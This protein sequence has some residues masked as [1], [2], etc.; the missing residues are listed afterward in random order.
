MEE[1]PLHAFEL[2]ELIPLV[3]AGIDISINKAVILM[4][5]VVGLVAFIMISAAAARK[6]VPGKLQNM[7]ELIVEFI[8]GIILDTMGEPA[9]LRVIHSLVAIPISPCLV[10][11]RNI[12]SKLPIKSEPTMDRPSRPSDRHWPIRPSQ[13]RT[14]CR[15]FMEA[16]SDISATIWFARSNRCPHGPSTTSAP[17]TCTWS[18]WTWWPPSIIKPASYTSCFARP[19][20]DSRLSHAKNSIAKAATG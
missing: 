6:L 17:R 18:F 1:S 11:R 20:P 19:C 15:P 2:H 13:N 4:W 10:A 8:R 9:G 3:P 5:I 7:A 16:P 12:R 14:A